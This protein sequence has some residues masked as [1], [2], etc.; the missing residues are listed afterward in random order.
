MQIFFNYRML[1]TIVLCIVASVSQARDE[2]PFDV[3]EI[4]LSGRVVTAALSDFDGDRLADLMIATLEGLPPAETR[5]LH[6]YLQSSAGVFGQTPSHSIEIPRHAAVYDIADVTSQP[7]TELVL[8]RPDGLTLL[9]VANGEELE[10]HLAAPGPSTIAA[11]SD[12]RGFDSF[13]LAFANVGGK[14]RFLVPQIGALGVLELDGRPVGR[15]DTGGRAN[16]Y[17]A[18]RDS[19]VA[20][21]S[22]I[23]L[24]L[25]VPKLSV[26]DINGD[27][28][29]D[30]VA[31]TRHEVRTFVSRADGS[32]DD[33]PTAVLPLGLV[34]E[35][36]HRRGS[37]GVVVT[38]SDHNGD[39]LMD[40][41]ISHVEGSFASA[42]TTT[43]LYRNQGKGWHLD[44]PSD[45][46][47]TKGALSSDILIDIDG[48]AALELL[49][50]K[51]KFS[52]LELVEMLLTREVDA[53]MSLHR[54]NED[55]RYADKPWSRKKIS[56]GISFETFR[57][58][59]FMPRGNVDLNADGLM[60]FVASADGKAL[61]V[62]LG[63]PEGPFER[64]N[65][66]Q[67]IPTA[68]AIRFSDYNGDGLTDFVLFDSQS[69]EPIV[70]I[71]R[72]TGALG[73]RGTSK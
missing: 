44:T 62:Y 20:V 7:G 37:G 12:E 34:T 30:I 21:E 35:K 50:I 5:Q 40:L 69:F 68:G 28:L 18:R 60:D 46:F 22:D 48:D 67:K 70:R 55:G 64:R 17:V 36:D 56:T 25:D 43:Y 42:V 57:P 4:A 6:V 61:E 27:G 13:K 73:D 47:T 1:A 2:P 59:G 51:V 11:S 29:G 19:M 23:Q 65:A 39:G 15:L 53:V 3:Q 63:G 52:V 24:F 26:G 8:L 71:G 31:A 10:Q 58:K 14:P 45:T 33:A 16:Y 38:G 41:M 9:S 72:N 32:F 54:L 66:R 49:R